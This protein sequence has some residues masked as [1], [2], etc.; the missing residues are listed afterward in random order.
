MIYQIFLSY[1]YFP[2]HFRYQFSLNFK[3]LFISFNLLPKALFYADWLW[4]TSSLN[5]MV[6]DD[7]VLE[8][9][10]SHQNHE[11]SHLRS[12]SI[13]I[14]S[15]LIFRSNA[16]FS[17]D[18]CNLLG[19][20]HVMQYT[21]CCLGDIFFCLYLIF[22]V[23]FTNSQAI[24]LTTNVPIVRLS[25]CAYVPMYVIRNH[26]NTYVI[27]VLLLLMEISNLV[28]KFILLRRLLD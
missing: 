24:S 6:Y 8:I 23:A 13:C 25:I 3:S 26:C 27:R 12:C 5:R 7:P 16:P 28:Y 22:F 21:F 14:F 11:P 20:K 4:K 19:V 9:H 2:I 15:D 10:V 17:Q 1:F 18:A